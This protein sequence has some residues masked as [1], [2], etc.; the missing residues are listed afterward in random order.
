MNLKLKLVN[1]NLKFDIREF[2]EKDGEL[3]PGK[4]GILKLFRN[5]IAN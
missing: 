5:C 3:L 4:K 2:Y 1:F